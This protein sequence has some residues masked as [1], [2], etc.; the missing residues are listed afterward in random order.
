M[1][2]EDLRVKD[3]CRVV[4]YTDMTRHWHAQN[5]GDHFIGIKRKGH[6]LHHFSHGDFML[7]PGSVYYFNQKDDYEVNILEPGEA[8]SVHFTT[9]FPIDTDSFSIPSEDSGGFIMLLEKLEAVQCSAS[10]DTFSAMSVF[11][12]LCA[13]IN[14]QRHHQD[15]ASH[16]KIRHAKEYLRTHFREP[17][18]VKNAAEICGISERWFRELFSAAYAMTPNQYLALQRIEYAK[19]LLHSGSYSLEETAV[20]CGFRDVY[21]FSKCFKNRTGFSPGAYKKYL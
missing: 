16:P 21:Y 1:D 2:F 15:T 17:H 19:E 6:A 11:F 20:L 4:R 5:R 10:H 7:S 3:I 8:F 14:R 18:A 12:R 9:F 13:E